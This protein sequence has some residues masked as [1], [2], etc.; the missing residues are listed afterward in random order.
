MGGGQSRESPSEKKGATNPKNGSSIEKIVQ[1]FAA[2]CV[3]RIYFSR[4]E[5]TPIVRRAVKLSRLM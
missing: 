1:A 5:E 2:L 3:L 4:K